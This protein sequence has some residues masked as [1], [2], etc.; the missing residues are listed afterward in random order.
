MSTPVTPRSAEQAREPDRQ[1]PRAR[2]AQ[3]RGRRSIECEPPATPTRLIV[4]AGEL[5]AMIAEAAYLRA[6]RRA[7]AP[8]HELDDWL[9]AERD[10]EQALGLPSKH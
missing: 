3:M 9:Q 7:F 4:H 2:K 1:A 8:G 6:E 5:H 10:I